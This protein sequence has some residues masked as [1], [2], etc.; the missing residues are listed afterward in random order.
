MSHEKVLIIGGGFAG[1]T[2]ALFLKFAG[3]EAEIY[4]AREA[5][6]LD[7]GAFLFIAPNGMNV[8]KELG[9]GATLEQ[10]GFPITGI[11][12]YNGQ[13][14]TIGKLDNRFDKERYGVRGHV[15]KRKDIFKVLRDEAQRQGIPIHFGKR[16]EQVSRTTTRIE[17]IF[18]SGTTATGD[19]L[20][21]A[22]GINSSTRQV[23]LPTSP[24]PNYA[25]LVD[26]GGF[27]QLSNLRH[28]T[29]PQHMMFGKRAFFGYMVKPSGEVYWFSNVPWQKEPTRAELNAI[30]PEAWKSK[31]LELHRDDPEPILEII[32]ATPAK[33]F[34]KWSTRDMPSL[35]TWYKDRVCVMGDAAHATSP[36][37]GQG[38]SMALEDAITLAKCL[39][40][41]SNAEQAL[42]TFQDL[43]KARVENIIQAARRNG[44]RKIPSPIMGF[45]RDLMLPQFLKAGATSAHRTYA[46]KVAWAEKIA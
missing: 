19:L 46:Y 9:L 40:D 7:A 24:K 16:L 34:G 10:H 13:G 6:D 1:T 20:I 18:Q 31:L 5:S 35:P 43:R 38:A 39:R 11:T 3:I 22:D 28:L 44:S 32:K 23:I 36:S 45:L 29:G 4:E 8:L 15:F 21:G 25:G 12:F 26:T 2:L 33:E 17:A 27:A 30:S 41:I 42:A 37:A 14:K